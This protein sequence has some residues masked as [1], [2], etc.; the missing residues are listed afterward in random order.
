M[1]CVTWVTQQTA[2]IQ[3]D[4]TRARRTCIVAPCSRTAEGLRCSCSSPAVAVV[5]PEPRVSF[6]CADAPGCRR[7]ISEAGSAMLLGILGLLNPVMT[8]GK[9]ARGEV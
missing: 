9:R 7:L 5:E 1:I 3:T 4:M 6:S 8:A 2:F